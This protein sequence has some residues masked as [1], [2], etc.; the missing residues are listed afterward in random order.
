[1]SMHASGGLH[2]T[3]IEGIR[4]EIA[5]AHVEQLIEALADA[6]IGAP[7]WRTNAQALLRKLAAA[8]E[9]LP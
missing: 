7:H 5:E 4:R 1:M 2:V 8:K 6:L 9:A 3:E